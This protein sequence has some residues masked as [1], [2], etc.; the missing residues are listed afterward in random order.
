MRICDSA[1]TGQLGL[2]HL[3]RFWSR[4][5]SARAGQTASESHS[6]EWVASQTLLSGLDLGL[7]ET[8]QYLTVA[9]P[10]FDEFEH[11]ILERNSG[12]IEPAR[13][14]R[15]NA[16][17]SGDAAAAVPPDIEGDPPFTPADL[18]F[19]EEHGYVILH[20]AV[21]PENCE[22]AA[23]AIYEYVGADP[24]N[25]DTWYHQPQGHSIW[26]PVL[27]HPALRAN[28]KSPRIHRA[29]AQLWGRN[30]MWPVVDQG[31]FNP[32]ERPSWNFPGPFLHWDVSLARP[33]PFGV[34][35]ILYLTDTA[36]NQGAF[37]CVPGFHRRIESWLGSLAPGVNPRDLNLYELGPQPIAGKAGDLIIWH[38]A[39]PHGSSPNH[40]ARP[41]VVQYLSMR[42]S[43]WEYRETWE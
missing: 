5:L 9:Q 11:W 34:Q 3:K 28:R 14:A 16:A 19:W 35:G 30:D 4:Q 41:R 33:I 24:V 38:Q 31:G 21:P 10:T 39:L 36:A 20:D 40:G 8:L 1:E 7:H 6:A 22:A 29:F 23:Q 43:Q 37:T 32:P 18:S 12:T 42:P 2:R 26:I 17:L 13:I 25:S 15:I 27:R